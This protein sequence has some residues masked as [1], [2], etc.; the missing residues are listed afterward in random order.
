MIT[1]VIFLFGAAILILVGL[2][3][4]VLVDVFAE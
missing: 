2:L 1:A 4:I 3:A